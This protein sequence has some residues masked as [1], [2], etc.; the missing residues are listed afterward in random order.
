MIQTERL[1][2]L[3]ADLPKLDA[4]VKGEWAVLSRLL[5]GVDIA[6]KWMH[7]PEA[8]VWMRDYLEEH[9]IDLRWWN[10]LIIHR[11]DVRLIGTC[12]YKGAPGIEGEVEIGYEIAES[13]QGKGL[14]TETARAL[15]DFAFTEPEVQQVIAHTLAEENPSSH[16]LKKMGFEFTGEIVDVEDGLIWGWRMDRNAVQR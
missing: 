7:F 14:G 1:F 15:V 3:Q 11:Q 10:Y 13:Y 6:E 16:L 9:T 2:L 12:G 8:M 4:I 5:G